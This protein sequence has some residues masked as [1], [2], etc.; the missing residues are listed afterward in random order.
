MWPPIFAIGASS[1]QSGWTR[2]EWNQS[3]PSVGSGSWPLSARRA[4]RREFRQARAWR[5]RSS[6]PSQ[7]QENWHRCRPRSSPCLTTA[8]TV[9][10]K[11][12]APTRLSVTAAIAIWPRRGSERASQ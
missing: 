4:I 7:Y 12:G 3:A 2:S 1:G 9:S 8:Q 10:G 6:T 5:G 11:P